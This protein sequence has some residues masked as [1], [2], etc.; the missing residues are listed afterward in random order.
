MRL[1]AYN[2]AIKFA[3]S[4]LITSDSATRKIRNVF[5]RL[6]G[7]LRSAS[8]LH[9][10]NSRS[11]CALHA[12]FIFKLVVTMLWRDFKVRIYNIDDRLLVERAILRAR[13]NLATKSCNSF[14]TR[15]ISASEM[16][17]DTQSLLND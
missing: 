17:I 6:A 2:M 16:I 4:E 7:Q 15:L 10:L 12:Q 3:E 5:V 9:D 1:S 14:Q 11:Y 13:I 8:S